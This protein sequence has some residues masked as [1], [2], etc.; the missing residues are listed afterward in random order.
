MVRYGLVKRKSLMQADL[1]SIYNESI[2][3]NHKLEST[4]DLVLTRI[5]SKQ[6]SDILFGILLFDY[7]NICFL[8][9]DLVFY[10]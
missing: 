9:W 8:N 10:L 7:I 3:K 4:R 5:K 1:S 6:F 2:K